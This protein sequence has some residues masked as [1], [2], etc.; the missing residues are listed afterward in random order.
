MDRA[1]I[2]LGDKFGF[3]A[4][5]YRLVSP[6]DNC[7]VIAFQGSNALSLM[8][9]DATAGFIKSWLLANSATLDIVNK[10]GEPLID[11]V[12]KT[13]GAGGFFETFLNP[14]KAPATA[15]DL[16]DL[17]AATVVQQYRRDM[18]ILTGH[19]LGGGMAQY[20][21][22]KNDLRAIVFNSAGTG[23]TNSA[24]N[25]ANNIV[26]VDTS[27]NAVNYL[28]TDFSDIASKHYGSR[29]FIGDGGH[30][31]DEVIR[32]LRTCALPS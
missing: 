2:A 8:G 11:L 22:M 13:Y 26:R 18:I 12:T 32:L 3:N 7:Q 30:E 4:A 17:L 19:S 27:G 25:S 6:F 20:A 14:R 5:L 23:L 21:A 10:I 24:P 28:V 9:P 1:E 16:A 31:I 15:Y 29:Y